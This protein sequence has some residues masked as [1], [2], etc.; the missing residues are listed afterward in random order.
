MTP[1]FATNYAWSHAR[2][3][4]IVATAQ[5]FVRIVNLR[6]ARV[7]LGGV[8]SVYTMESHRGRGLGSALMRLAGTTMAREGFEVSLLFAERLD[9]YTR[10]GWR[11]VTRQ[12]SAIADT[13]TMRTAAR[14]RLARFEEARDLREVAVLHRDYSGRFD[15]TAIR[16]TNGWRGNLH[17]AGSPCEYF[18]VCRRNTSDEIV[19]YARAMLFHGF[20]KW[21]TATRRTRRTRYSC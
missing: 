14:F 9:F 15:S 7:P 5:I 19:A 2:A 4:V 16:D 21:S 6:G 18:V 8:G 17:Y 12:F 3:A 20:P 13:R 1:A 10:F 11:P